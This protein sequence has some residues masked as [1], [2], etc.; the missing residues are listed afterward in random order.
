MV[1]PVVPKGIVQKVQ[2]AKIAVFSCPIELRETETKGT[3]LLE[4]A[5]D[6]RGLNAGEEAQ[7]EELIKS[8]ADAGINVLV[9]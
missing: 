1:I 3:I 5:E 4:A 2:D 8:Y 9:S 7:Y 6:L